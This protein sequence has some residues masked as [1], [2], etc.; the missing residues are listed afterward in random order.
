MNI[1]YEYYR[2]QQIV[3]YAGHAILSRAT[4]EL[5]ALFAG[6]TYAIVKH[7]QN[8]ARMVLRHHSGGSYPSRQFLKR[9]M[10]DGPW[11]VPFHLKKETPDLRGIFWMEPTR[12][13]IN[14]EQYPDLCVS[15]SRAIK[16]EHDGLGVSTNFTCYARHNLFILEN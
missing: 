12:V 3:S 8:G 13:V 1:G 16:C 9:T 4:P 2:A 10:N 5:E 15:C 7:S 11:L 6:G 14:G